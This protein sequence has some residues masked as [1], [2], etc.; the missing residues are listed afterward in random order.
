MSKSAKSKRS[1]APRVDPFLEGLMA[2]LLDRLGVLERKMDTVV[3]QTAGRPA[4]AP[5]QQS[6]PAQMSFSNPHPMAEPKN[7]PRREQRTM[8]E[9]VCADCNDPCEVP[10]RPSPERA[11]YCKPCFAKR[12]AEGR[13]HP[14]QGRPQGPQGPQGSQGPGGSSP[15]AAVMTA[16]AA[17]TAAKPV[18]V[19]SAKAQ[20]PAKKSKPAPAKK[21]KKK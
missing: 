4:S 9:A 15:S 3:A 11:I 2:K 21:A 18:Q 10:F 17:K 20:Q 5:V 7:L 14:S 8:Y 1:A 12:R 19:S 16:P 13:V 6:R